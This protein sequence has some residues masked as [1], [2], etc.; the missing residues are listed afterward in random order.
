M[1]CVGCPWLSC[2][3]K[4]WT[5][6]TAHNLSYHIIQS[7]HPCIYSFIHVQLSKHSPFI[8]IT[9][10]KGGPTHGFKNKEFILLD[11]SMNFLFCGRCKW[12]EEIYRAFIRVY[13][14]ILIILF[15]PKFGLHNIPVVFKIFPQLICIQ[16]GIQFI[17]FSL[18][19]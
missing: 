8:L 1:P 14:E 16:N 6:F 5:S 17:H 10:N 7:I 12:V 4:G 2:G 15:Y 9:E 11:G 19:F 18:L 13:T 3:L